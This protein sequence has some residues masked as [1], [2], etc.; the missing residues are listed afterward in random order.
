MPEVAVLVGMSE[1]AARDWAKRHDLPLYGSRPVRL[2]E[3]DVL[4]QITDEGRAPRKSPEVAPEAPGSGSEAPGR[5]EPIE[6]AYTT[7]GEGAPVALVPLAA[8]AAQ[9]QGL[10]DRL[11]DMALEVGQLRE[12]TATQETTIADL[13]RQLAEAQSAPPAAPQPPGA[14]PTPGAA[15]DTPV[16]PEAAQGLWARVRRAFGGG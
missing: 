5:S 3:A 1:R 4:A 15:M 9:L 14:A 16:A 11:A 8:V 13:R 10:A 2:A 6:A 7:A 12:R